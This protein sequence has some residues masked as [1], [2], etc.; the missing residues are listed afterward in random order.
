MSTPFLC[1]LT[2][3]LASLAGCGPII[4]ADQARMLSVP[5]EQVTLADGQGVLSYLRAGESGRP[6]LVYVHGTPGDA[7]EWANYLTSPVEGLES[8]AV[9]RLGFGQSGPAATTSFADHARSLG[10]LL[11]EREGQWPILLGHSLGG[12]IV[13][14]AAANQPEKVRAIV[15]L[16]GSL[17]PALEEPKWYN[18]AA[19]WAIFSWLLSENLLTANR[20]I[21]AARRETLALQGALSGVRCPVVVVQGGKDELVPRA[22]VEY[23]KRMFVS[24]ASMEVIELPNAGHFLPWEHEPV[25]RSAIERA[26][27]ASGRKEP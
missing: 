19:E 9:D 27:R 2:L 23:M 20:E 17:D 21:M 13:A 1:S 15:I 7:T 22:N 25:V 18:F 10:P 11:V 5:R 24:A 26:V 4:V 6:R 3:V 8:I 12:P 14:L 16:A